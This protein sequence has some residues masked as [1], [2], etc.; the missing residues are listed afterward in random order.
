ME[1]LVVPLA[2][3]SRADRARVGGKAAH[4]GELMR[5]GFAVP[6]GFALTAAAYRLHLREAGL[7]ALPGDG[8]R[9]GAAIMRH[10]V[11]TAVVDAVKRA[12]APLGGDLAVRSSAVG[13]DAAGASFAGQHETRLG[14][15]G[16]GAVL[17]AVRACWASLWSER[18]VEYRAGR[19][20]AAGDM[21]CVVQHMVPAEAAGV[22]FTAD[23]V[24]G[25]RDRVV[26]N[27]VRGLGEALVSGR[28]SA[29]Q[30]LL[31]AGNGRV[32][33]GDAA[34]LP[35]PAAELARIAREVAACFG[36]PQDVEW[37]VAGGRV[38]LLQARPITSLPPEPVRLED[39]E[40][41]ILYYPERV[42]EM[43]PGPITPLTAEFAVHVVGPAVQQN[44]VRHGLLPR[45]VADGLG[46]ANTIR[47]GRIYLE[48]DILREGFMPALDELALVELMENG[49]RPPL[50]ALRPSFLLRT[51]P[52]A[53]KAAITGARMLRRLD[54]LAAE[55]CRELDAIFAPLERADLAQWTDAELTGLLRLQHPPGVLERIVATPPAN[56]M[57]RLMGTPFYTALE[58]LA[59]RWGGEPAGTA[60]VLVSALPGLPEVAC[61]R[62][63][64]ALADDARRIRPVRDALERDAPSARD[65]LADV[66]EAR[67]WL[68]SFQAFLDRFGHRAIEEVELARPRWREQ[69][70]YV[71]GVIASYARLPPAASPDAVETRRRQL[72]DEA[73]ARI[74]ARLRWRP[75]RRR[76]F[77]L[78]LDV[79]R[80]A[81][82]AGESTKF[83][84]VRL[85]AL[86]RAAALEL[87][88]RRVEAG[89]LQ[90]AD[91]VFFL[92]FPELESGPGD[93]R[94][95]AAARREEHRRQQAQDPPR[96][97]DARH[98]PVR[99]ARRPQPSP[100]EGELHGIA[101]SPGLVRGPV[102]V[103]LDPSAG[104]DLRAGD[105]L[106]APFTDPAWTPL[107]VPAAAVVVE[108]GSL[109]SH[110]SIVARE[111]GLPSVVA[112]RGATRLLRDGQQVEVDGTRGLVRIL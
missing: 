66:A 57:A 18:A 54:A 9:T 79:A 80:Q 5:A 52:G 92:R 97:I 32:V 81:S 112:V 63:L 24:T 39:A 73:E 76:V 89:R 31:D 2:A 21:A 77:D 74:R 28:V 82:S 36:A 48:L 29:A 33:D 58:R 87:G 60:A 101:A 88:R 98:R 102:R 11:P 13:E 84:I 109:L 61:A 55:C 26:V 22:L 95:I 30:A 6:D 45:K 105:V 69:P 94:A 51:G 35:V 67:A 17:D 91:D 14:V 40:R 10:A 23:P 20:L 53:L 85:L 49:R 75:L 64:W 19:G 8:A 1:P 46:H 65:A 37:A 38:F 104:F 15:R 47:D 59:T 25:E 106:V 72:R 90:R 4:L 71:L 3:A 111:L 43:M 110:A 56:P 96:L 108:T 27:V 86:V 70:A 62:A 103:L 50:R 34:V 12:L 7:E 68:A 44:L 107:F 78:V 16:L 42:K 41:P 99:E 100:T 93:L 83:E